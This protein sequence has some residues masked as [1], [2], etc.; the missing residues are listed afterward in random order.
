[1]AERSF[2]DDILP[3]LRAWFDWRMDRHQTD[4]LHDAAA[5]RDSIRARRFAAADHA[6]QS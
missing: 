3:E 6:L 4:P 5:D 1:M 2:T